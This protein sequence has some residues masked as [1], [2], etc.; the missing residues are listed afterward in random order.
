MWSFRKKQSGFSM[1]ET[2]VA[3][4]V[5]GA[6]AYIAVNSSKFVATHEKTAKDSTSV[7]HINQEIVRGALRA[8]TLS[9]DKTG[10]RNQ[11][12]CS[13]VSSDASSPGVGS[14]Y[15]NLKNHEKLF[16]GKRWET[17]LPNWVESSAKDCKMKNTWSKCFKP[18]SDNALSFSKQ[19]LKNLDL[20]ANV[21]ITP[22][23]MNAKLGIGLFEPLTS[24]YLKSD[25][26][27]KNV[28]FIVDSVVY[29]TEE[30]KTTRTQKDLKNYIWAP[31]VGIC[32]YKLSNGKTVKLSLSGTGA[33]DP[34]GNTVYNRSGFSGNKRDP[35]DISFRRSQAQEGV[36][37]ESGQFITTDTSKNIFGSCNEVKFR[38]P[39]ESSNK[40]EYGAIEYQTYLSY[41]RD[42]VLTNSTSMDPFFRFRIKKGGDNG[43]SPGSYHVNYFFDASPE[44]QADI[45]KAKSEKNMPVRVRGSH[46]LV[47]KVTDRAGTQSANNVCRNICNENTNYNTNGSDYLQRFA[48]FLSYAF[49][50]FKGEVFNQSTTEQVGCTACY[51][52]NCDQ[53]GLGTFGPMNKQPN[54]PLDSIIPEC[55]LK[56]PNDVVLDLQPFKN[57]TKDGGNWADSSKTC[58]A[59]QLNASGDGLVLFN[60]NCDQDLPVMCYNYGTYLLARDVTR[61]AESISKVK[62]QSAY[63]RCF[64]MGREQTPIAELNDY[65][66]SS[67]LPFPTNG[68]NYDFINLAQQGFFFA[69]QTSKDVMDYKRWTK[70]H[71]IPTSTKFW[72]A[73]KRD[74]DKQVIADLPAVANLSKKSNFALYFDGSGKL[75]YKN[76]SFEMD[77]DS[78]PAS[79]PY[80]MMLTNHLKYKG[81][82]II[83]PNSP[84]TSG[85]AMKFLCRKKSYPHDF[86]LSRSGANDLNRG[87]E[88][89]KLS[90]GVFVPPTTPL[91]WLKAMMLV[92]KF[93]H[94]FP[95]HDPNID[96]ASEV[97]GVWVAIS[98]P[99]STVTNDSW[100]P[101]PIEGNEKLWSNAKYS[102]ESS[103]GDHRV[104]DGRGH[105][106]FPRAKVEGGNFIK[107]TM[108]PDSIFKVKLNGRK[109]IEIKFNEA[110][111]ADKDYT[112]EEV[113]SMFNS[114]ASGEAVMSSDKKGLTGV[115]KTI[116]ISSLDA[117]ENSFIGIEFGV[118][119]AASELGFSEGKSVKAPGTDFK[120]CYN[121]RGSIEKKG[122]KSF[123]EREV[124]YSEVRD[125]K[126][127]MVLFALAGLRDYDL[128]RVS[129]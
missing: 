94:D 68:A 108:K 98:T 91:G 110:G 59:A 40:R 30:G 42:N 116:T 75:A 51:M 21:K 52:K 63:D 34:D 33:S 15:I 112:V 44:D 119:G 38:C 125:S 23:S 48:P 105:F 103:D 29:Y 45:S 66:E 31:N 84:R 73:L 83:K 50:D 53:F 128:F 101:Y 79:G 67:S 17:F 22:V 109:T 100:L 78:L 25:T 88:R 102:P 6:G 39:Q 126:E 107:V 111:T 77:L 89:C 46:E 121:R 129:N 60:E 55:S 49:S 96:E 122:F 16:N 76:Y 71:S 69:P 123:C 57:N 32:D 8:L 26:D 12:I 43:Q 93:D 127:F 62:Y 92:E 41:N 115:S 14:I 5:I 99:N 28:G 81:L 85:K 124:K 47:V 65:M 13:L 4:G 64:K 87:E 117:S 24:K 80:G 35:L 2:I 37:D 90:G 70:K 113:I 11:G 106:R 10:L 97:N 86:F 61:T 36:L 9:E 72:V 120:L 58:I 20:V 104:I 3:L 95:F 56:E 114:A 118:N 54:Q 18:S 1:L 19:Q 82:Q 27:V 74:G 7:S